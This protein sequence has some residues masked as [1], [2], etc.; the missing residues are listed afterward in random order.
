MVAASPGDVGHIQQPA[1][2]TVQI[3]RLLSTL[4]P[5]QSSLQ[6]WLH[7]RNIPSRDSDHPH[8]LIFLLHPLQEDEVAAITAQTP[9]SLC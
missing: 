2:T 1:L 5:P 7:L 6:G 4:R 9:H 8:I 3:C